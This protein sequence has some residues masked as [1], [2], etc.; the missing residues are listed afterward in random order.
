MNQVTV[1]NVS[2][3]KLEKIGFWLSVACAIHCLAMPVVIT[4]LP[5]VGSTLLADHETEFYVL[6]SSWVLA[7]ILLFVDYRKHQNLWPLAL[8]GG[9]IAIK[10]LEI[11]VLGED[12]EVIVSPISGITIAVAYYFNW[13]YKKTCACGHDH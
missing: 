7:G 5:F 9:S 12:F 10:L 6:S 1:E 8:L 13:R 4:L 2:S 11:F 3:S